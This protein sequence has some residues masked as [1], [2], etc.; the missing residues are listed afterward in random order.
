M[1]TSVHQ[2]YINRFLGLA[3]DPRCLSALLH[4]SFIWANCPFLEKVFT[5][6]F[7]RH[8]FPCMEATFARRITDVFVVTK[9]DSFT[10]FF[11]CGVYARWWHFLKILITFSFLWCIFIQKVCK[12]VIIIDL[13][14]QF[15]HKVGPHFLHF[16]HNFKLLFFVTGK[17]N[18]KRWWLSS[19]LCLFLQ[20]SK[21]NN[22]VVMMSFNLILRSVEYY[23]G[24]FY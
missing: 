10:V 1:C 11:F 20:L 13:P 18:S 14:V 5:I 6:N 4:F 2:D 19:F 22:E 21:N 17:L 12:D 8:Y 9:K 24:M 7:P 15:L 3:K 23:L 16:I